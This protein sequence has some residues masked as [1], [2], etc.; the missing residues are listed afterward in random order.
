MRL[1]VGLNAV[2]AL[3]LELALLAAAVVIGLRLPV[4]FPAAVVLA[5][6]VPAAVITVWGL[7]L[8]PR[9]GHR[10]GPGGRLLAETALFALAAGGLAA[11]GLPVVGVVLA[12]LAAVRLMLGTALGRV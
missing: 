12:V 5:V 9:A 2:L 3:L 1:L 6:A 4:P 11:T 10:L 8:A 7:L